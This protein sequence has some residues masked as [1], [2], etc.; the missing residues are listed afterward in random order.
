MDVSG[1]AAGAIAALLPGPGAFP[2]GVC[3][4]VGVSSFVGRELFEWIAED[5]PDHNFRKIASPRKPRPPSFRAGHGL[6]AA[7][8]GALSAYARTQAELSSYLAAFESSYEHAAGVDWNAADAT[9]WWTR[10]ETAA[11]SYAKAAAARLQKLSGLRRTLITALGAKANMKLTAATY[12]RARDRIR[13]T[14]LPTSLTS[15]LSKLGW[16]TSQIRALRSELARISTN[17]PLPG[18]Q[19]CEVA[20]HKRSGAVAV[21]SRLTRSGR[22]SSAGSEIVVRHG[23]PRRFAPR[24]PA[25]RISLATRSRPTRSPS[26]A[27][28]ACILRTP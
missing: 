26:R 15:A 9:S 25:A 14:G 19:I 18:P 8:A 24:I 5:P 23:F 16:S 27:S 12:T 11:A 4:G 21:K 6:T 13:R 20:D 10:Q 3:A 28:A 17:A 22:F 2:A 7:Q 1:L